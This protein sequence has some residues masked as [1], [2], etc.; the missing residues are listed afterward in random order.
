MSNDSAGSVVLAILTVLVPALGAAGAW[1]AKRVDARRAEGEKRLSEQIAACD[2]ERQALRAEV[3]AHVSRLI[4]LEVAH[5][6]DFPRWVRSHDGVIVSVSPAF[7]QHVAAP[8]GYRA[9]DVVGRRFED[10][11]KFD[12]ALVSILAQLDAECLNSGYASRCG[13]PIAAGVTATVVKTVR[14]GQMGDVVF[15]GI[16]CPEI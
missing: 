12:Q 9:A 3:A 8:R 4:A 6:G 11:P 14:S 5:G 2:S 7:V 10:L 13:V 15:I 1:I 16:I